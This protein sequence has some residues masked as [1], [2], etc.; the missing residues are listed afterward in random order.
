MADNGNNS[1]GGDVVDRLADEGGPMET[2][3]EE[4]QPAG[5]VEG[6][7]A[8]VAARGDDEGDQE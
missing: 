4:Q 1:G 6:I 8:A 7:G 5:A 3:I 2:E